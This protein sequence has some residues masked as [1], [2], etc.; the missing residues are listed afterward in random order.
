MTRRFN[1]LSRVSLSGLSTTSDAALATGNEWMD[2]LRDDRTLLDAFRRGD[3]KALQQVYF[4]Y[5]EEVFAV[6]RRGFS[7]SAREKQYAFNGYKTAWQLESAVQDVFL[8]AFRNAARLA[9]DGQ[10]PFKGYLFTIARNLVMDR[11]RKERPG[12]LDVRELHDIDDREMVWERPPSPEQIAGDREL[13]EAVQ[14]F[15]EALKTPAR[16]FFEIR[17]VEGGSLEE[18][19]RRLGVGAGITLLGAGLLGG[20]LLK[21]RNSRQPHAQHRALP[22]GTV[23]SGYALFGAMGEF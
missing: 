12:R 4:A 11:F 1:V 7:F 22:F 21:Y 20:D 13:R 23:G 2:L 14:R 6:L 8:K 3:E 15:V 9:Y 5:A 16:A 18:A 19:S 10:R 17:F